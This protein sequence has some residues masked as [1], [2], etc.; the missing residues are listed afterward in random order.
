[1]ELS[2]SF[3]PADALISYLKGINYQKHLKTLITV[4]LTIAAF[5]YVAYQKTSEWYQNGGKDATLQTLIKIRNFLWM[6]CLWVRDE[7]YPALIKMIDNV[8]QTYAAW[9]DLVTV[10]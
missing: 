10:A 2:P 6:C 7:A 4:I 8:K 1:M 3:P 9:Q 5:L